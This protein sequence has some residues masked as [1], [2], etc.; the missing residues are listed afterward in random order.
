MGR[1]Y[2]ARDPVLARPVA[3]KV[4]RD[5]LGLP[6][7][8]KEELLGR[9]RHEARAVAAIG[10]PC[11]VTLHDMGEDE[12]AGLYLVFEYVE[13]PT[14][15]ARLAKG[16]LD[17]PEVAKL[18]T[19][20][21]AALS[22]AHEAGVVHRDVKPENVLLAATGAK[23][24][25]FGIARLPDST[26]TKAGTM[27]GTPAYSAPEA[28]ARSEH[29][30]ASDQFSLACTLYEAAGGRRAF[31]GDDALSVASKIAT[32]DPPPLA[33]AAQDPR[34]RL[35]YARL[36][37][38]LAKGFA[39]DPKRRYRS[40]LALG[41]MVGG[42][43]APPNSGAFP[44]L[45][46]AEMEAFSHRTSSVPHPVR[47]AQNIFAGIALIV[48][49]VLVLLGRRRPAEEPRPEPSAT[50]SLRGPA[51]H[52]KATAPRTHALPSAAPSAAPD[53]G[54]PPLPQ[55]F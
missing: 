39:K 50:A 47:R 41:T 48:I 44:S 51:P 32:E 14:L 15:R 43:I 1:V 49:V 28:L 29:S 17:L 33:Q 35:V 7:D 19:E 6:P 3:I 38:A 53:A 5:D 12:H 25:D 52:P 27:L 11:L 45:R 20:L 22:F 54:E 13:G 55:R 34:V 2:L 21:G 37:A 36:D 26:L 46:A 31:Q 40:C 16:P 10:H 42:A 9:M 23:L 4:L 24:A 18:A 30:P 8:V